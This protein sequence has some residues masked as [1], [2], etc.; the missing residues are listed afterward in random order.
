LTD[1]VEAGFPNLRFLRSDPIWE[2]VHDDPRF[3]QA[4]QIVADDL[5]RQRTQLEPVFRATR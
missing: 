3:L 4:V 1:A 5:D 2:A